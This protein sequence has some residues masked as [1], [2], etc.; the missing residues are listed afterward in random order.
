MHRLQS[1]PT[2]NTDTHISTYRECIRR[3]TFDK[4]LSYPY[5]ADMHSP[6]TEY[7][8]VASSLTRQFGQKDSPI[9]AV[10]SVDFKIPSG[11]FTVILGKS[12]SGK[13]TLLNM[14]T[15]LDSPSSGSL[16][17]DDK[18][19]SQYSS[20]QLAKYRS[21]IGIVFQSYNLLPNLNAIENILMSSWSSSSGKKRQ[22][23]EE[24]MDTFGL[25]HRH[26]ANV[27]TLSGGEK[28]R[29]A[30]C[31]SLLNKPNILFCDEPTG[32]LDS[33]NESEVMGLLQKLHA[34]GMTIVM[35]THAP[36]FAYLATQV[37]TMKD[38]K[39]QSI[40]Q[41]QREEFSRDTSQLVW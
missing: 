24:L 5:C 14:L 39:I 10:D 12:G 29:V 27:K 11:S 23:A 15:G 18:D 2:A 13:S 4:I 22:D 6:S 20:G 32:A 19:I 40:E 36:E 8:I 21:S 1:A 26:T 28:Q 31:R 16:V 17:I 38:G 41:K 3:Y 37:I 25:N 35:V 33:T 9:T 34:N 30:L 7:R